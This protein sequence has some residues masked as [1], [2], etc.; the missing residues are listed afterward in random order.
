M[1]FLHEQGDDDFATLRTSVRPGCTGIWQVSKAAAGLIWDSAEYDRFY[2]FN[3]NLRLDF[4]I[5]VR[6]VLIM[7]PFAR[8]LAVEDV[9]PWLCNRRITAGGS[10][11][12]SSPPEAGS[13]PAPAPGIIDLTSGSDAT[14]M[15]SAV[16]P[17]E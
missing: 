2:V 10:L 16:A 17:L 6:T 14:A 11:E 15:R 9:P 4:W 12:A 7:T 5:M 3:R 1:V 13:S 8:P